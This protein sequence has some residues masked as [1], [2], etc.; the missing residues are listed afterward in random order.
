MTDFVAHLT[1]QAAVS[2]ATFG[3][4]SRTKGVIDHIKEE[5]GEVEKVYETPLSR[6]DSSPRA[7]QETPLEPPLTRQVP[8]RNQHE[9]AALEWTDVAILGLDGLLR[10]ISAAHPDWTFQRV[11]ERAVLYITAKQGKNELRD[12]PNWR[13]VSEDKAI[14]HVRGKLD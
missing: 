4:G 5:L 10:A 14:K 7:A 8:I 6:F 2:R 1:R 11:A 12:W 13:D 3:P 9:A